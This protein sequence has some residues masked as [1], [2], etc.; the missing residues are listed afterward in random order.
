MAE[1]AVVVVA[2]VAVTATAMWLVFARRPGWLARSTRHRVLVHTV[3]GQ[4]I[5]GQLAR[6][7][8]DGLV[9]SPA[10]WESVDV[11]GEVFVPRERVGWCQRPPQR[12]VE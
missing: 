5:D 3:D 12:G 9:L 7:D 6:V 4:T 2:F 11:G 8:R 10:E 1:A